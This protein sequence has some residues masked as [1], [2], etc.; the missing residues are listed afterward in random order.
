MLSS[1]S[2]IVL[3]TGG[4]GFL[5][6]RLV[7][8]LVRQQKYRVRALV[9]QKSRMDTIA[10]TWGCD[11]SSLE[12]AEG[13]LLRREDCLAA[14]EGAAIVYHLAA[15]TGTKSFPWAFRNSDV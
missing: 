3:V 9:R 14:T 2:P 11:T 4:A 5:G 12:V 6:S 10:S 8:L 13:N 7:E 15:G 1:N